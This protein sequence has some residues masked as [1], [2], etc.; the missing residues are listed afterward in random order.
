M[1]NHS[2]PE[3]KDPQ[4][5]HIARK[6]AS[7]KSHLLTY[8]IVNIGLWIL[9]YLTGARR[10]GNSIPWPAWTTIGWGIGVAF[11][12]IGAYTRA[13]DNSIE[14]EYDKLTQKQNQ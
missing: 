6:R 10:D 7:F 13:G 3:G 1:S 12:Y 9:W 2:T 5:W 11:H 4:L 8:I 14:K